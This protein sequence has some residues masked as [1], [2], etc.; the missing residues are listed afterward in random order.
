MKT[1]KAIAFYLPQ[2]HPIKENNEWWGE[3]FTEWTNVGKAKKL[4]KNHYQPKIPADLGYYDLRLSETRIKQAELAK[5]Y[6]IDGFCYYHYWFGEGKQLLQKPF[7]DV[8]RLGEPD[9]PFMLCWANESWYSKFWN[10]DGTIDKKL[11]IEQKYGDEVEFTNHFEYVL[12]AF[13]DERYIKIDGKPAFMI[14]LPND[15]KDVPRFIVKWQEL[16]KENGLEGVFFIAQTSL[17]DEESKLLFKMGFDA[18]NTTRLRDVIT[19]RSLGKRFLSRIKRNLF[20]LP[21]VIDYKEATKYFITDLEKEENV[22]PSIYPNWDHTPRSGT[23]GYVLQNS[24]PKKFGDHLKS[25][26]AVIQRKPNN[27]NICFI[28]SWNEWGEGNYLE[29]D[30]KF[31]HEYLAEFLRVKREYEKS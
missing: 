3:G 11:L 27:R 30:L 14:Y 19:K 2:Y 23:G 24:T 15:F 1:I 8:L 28:K 21:I 20:K 16:A 4:F 9:F 26:F 7:E 10:M 12:K 22:F 25:V 13:Q 29:P 31:G 6:G 5:Q 18:V 17:P